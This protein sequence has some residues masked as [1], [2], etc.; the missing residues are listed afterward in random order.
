MDGDTISARAERLVRIWN[1]DDGGTSAGPMV[2][3]RGTHPRGA[4][5]N[6]DQSQIVTLGRQWRPR[7]VGRWGEQE[8]NR[9]RST[10]RQL[11]ATS[12]AIRC[13]SNGTRVL[14]WGK[15]AA[16]L[17]NATTGM[18]LTPPLEHSDPVNGAEFDKH[19]N[20]IFTWSNDGTARLWDAATWGDPLSPPLRHPPEPREAS[21][22]VLDG[23]FGPD[24]AGA[25]TRDEAGV[26]RVWSFPTDHSWPMNAL[27]VFASCGRDWSDP[28]AGYW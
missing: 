16:G 6:P 7:G 22:A 11:E 23:A 19:G 4:R 17:W 1:S 14:T 12:A 20:R 27:D 24:G 9:A 18:P 8:L 21:S 5:F 2:D 26:V 15:T 13:S 25:V 3:A 10:T 28:Q